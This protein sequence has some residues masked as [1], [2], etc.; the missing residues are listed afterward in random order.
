MAQVRRRKKIG[1]AAGARTAALLSLLEVEAGG[2][3]EEALDRHAADLDR[4]DRALAA[5]LVYGVLR[6]RL[7][8]DWTLKHFLKT[9]DKPLGPAVE[10][11]L[12]LGLFQ[13]HYLDRIPSSA[14][15]NESVKL[16]KAYG[17]AWSVKLVNA[18]L[19]SVTRAGNPP[20][21]AEFGL[22]L[23]EQWA[24]EHSH[25]VWLVERWVQ[26]LGR[27]ET[28]ALLAAYNTVPPLTLRINPARTTC[29]ELG[30]L[31]AGAAE[32]IE[33]SPYSPYGLSLYGPTGPVNDLPGYNEGLFAVQDEAAQVIGLL[34]DP[35]PGEKILDACAGRGGKSLHLAGLSP[36]RVIALDPDLVR[37]LQG[38]Q[39][40]GRLGLD[41]LVFIQGDLI[42]APPFRGESFGLV[43]VDAP[44]SNL[45]VIRRRPDIKWLKAPPDPAR[46]AGLQKRLLAAAADLVKPGGRLIYAVCTL[47]PEETTGVIEEFQKRRPGFT[48]RPAGDF[49]PQSARPLVADDGLVRAWPHRHNTDGF[50]AAVF[51]KKTQRP[52]TRP[53]SP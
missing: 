45:G 4:R 33:V 8:L 19:R 18:V 31:L 48:L 43:L 51:M 46:L 42:K 28:L 24:V 13:L 36:A 47:T 6:R 34:A 32:R 3:P 39:E 9:P 17:P 11:I 12:R 5:A 1:P 26:E 38:R 49:L 29:E 30:R 23:T 35:E 37:L 41:S 14:A 53:G 22:P 52:L 44:C 27:E 20:H 16:A 10:N 2:F 21:P 50:F 7:R 40:A 15:V 25:P